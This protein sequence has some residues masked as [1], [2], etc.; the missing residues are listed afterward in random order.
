MRRPKK[1]DSFTIRTSMGCH[2]G[3]VSDFEPLGEV[4][5]FVRPGSSGARVGIP[6]V[7]T[8]FSDQ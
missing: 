5:G 3:Q 1:E 8:K 4:K 2:S 7:P 6:S